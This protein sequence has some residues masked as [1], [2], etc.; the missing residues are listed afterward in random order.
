M[1]QQRLTDRTIAPYITGDTLIHI[2][3][4]GDTTQYAGG[5][6]YKAT[7]DQV[8]TYISENYTMFSGGSG[9]CI[10]DLYVSNIHSCSPLNINPLDEGNVYFGST[11][12]VT[13]DL[14]NERVGIGTTT[15]TEK[16]NVSGNTKIDI[17]TTGN[18]GGL[19]INNISGS[20]RSQIV[21]KS[22]DTFLWR[23]GLTS[24]TGN[25]SFNFY[26]GINDVLTI[27][28]EFEQ[29]GIGVNPNTFGTQAKLHINNTTTG[30]TFLAEDSTNPDS[31]PFVIDASGNVGIGISGTTFKL[32]VNGTTIHRDNVLISNSKEIFWSDTSTTWP[33]SINNRIRWTLNNDSA[34]VYA[35]QPVTDDVDFVF[36]I[37]DNATDSRDNFVFWIDDNGGEA[38]DRYPL[39]M[40]GVN[41]IVN[42]TRRYALSASTSASSVT[43][44]YVLKSGAT[45]TSSSILHANTSTGRVGINTSSPTETL[46]VNGKTKTINFQMTSGAT[47]GYVLTSDASGNA[48]WGSLYDKS[49]INISSATIL[50]TLSAGSPVQL[51]PAPSLGK[52]YD[53]HAF[54]RYTYGTIAYNNSAGGFWYIEQGGAALSYGFNLNAITTNWTWKATEGSGAAELIGPSGFETSAINIRLN[55]ATTNGDGTISVDIYYRELDL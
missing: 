4:T 45:S 44:F 15:P 1:S 51:L 34:Q 33:T 8:A 41:V 48:S 13:I 12:A 49:T 18:T 17:I 31:T 9:S 50:G 37:T 29:V 27:N 30:A 22:D 55:T 47:P 2:V 52:Y 46:D 14:V 42:P 10:A 35:F 24:G 53:W 23:F 28:R 3:N 19:I 25:T 6:S 43:N 32:D 40:N 38:N 5:S 11:S 36:K 20:T 26:N 54:V 16:L 39:E 21:L 7:I